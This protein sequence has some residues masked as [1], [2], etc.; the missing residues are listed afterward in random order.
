MRSQLRLQGGL[1]QFALRPCTS[2]D[3]SQGL[4]DRQP[5]VD[6]VLV[7]SIAPVGAA[8]GDAAMIDQLTMPALGGRTSGCEYGVVIYHPPQHAPRIDAIFRVERDE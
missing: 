7:K 8:V 4:C 3:G 1:L 6:A 2:G 5:A